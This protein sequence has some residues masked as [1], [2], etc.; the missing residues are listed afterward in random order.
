MPY[1]PIHRMVAESM[2]YPST[3]IV[4]ASGGRARPQCPNLTDL[5]PGLPSSTVTRGP[6]RVDPGRAFP[7]VRTS[8]TSL[9][10]SAP[11]TASR[12]TQVSRL[13]L[14]LSV[15]LSYPTRESDLLNKV[16]RR[17]LPSLFTFRPCHLVMC[18]RADVTSDMCQI[19]IV[20]SVI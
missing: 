8:S 20:H 3:A 17:P 9:P 2:A 11:S 4:M 6:S 14:R 15:P 18:H 16:H 10:R 12:P 5:P 13:P 1:V 19:K 7:A